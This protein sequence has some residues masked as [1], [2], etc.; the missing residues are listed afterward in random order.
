MTTP[1]GLTT[2]APGVEPRGEQSEQKS[3]NSLYPEPVVRLIQAQ[4]VPGCSD[5]VM[6]A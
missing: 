1:L 6:Y 2:S 3:E 4:K 5:A